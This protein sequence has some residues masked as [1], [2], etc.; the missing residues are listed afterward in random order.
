MQA[1]R[2]TRSD[3]LALFRLKKHYFISIEILISSNAFQYILFRLDEVILR[4]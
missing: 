2:A 4:F 1:A 3:F